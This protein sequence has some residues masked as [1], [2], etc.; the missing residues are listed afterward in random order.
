VKN[1]SVNFEPDF[2]NTERAFHLQPDSGVRRARFL[3][4]LLRY[5][6][7]MRILGGLTQLAIRLHLP[8]DFLIRRLIFNHFCAGETLSAAIPVMERL[9]RSGVHSIPDYSAEGKS[10][11]TSFERV[12]RE[13]LGTLE[14]SEEN[15]AVSHAV[16]KPSGIG[17]FGLWEQLS[18]GA[19][20]HGADL[21]AFEKLE[22]RLDRIFSEASRR[23]V[24]V[25]VDAEETWIQPAIDAMVRRYS[26][27]Y[28]R[29]RVIVYNTLQMYR[30]DRLGF[31]ASE[32]ELARREGYFLGYKIVRGAYHEQEIQR[33]EKMGYPVP[34]YTRKEETDSAYDEAVRFCFANREVIGCCVATHNEEST[35]RLARLLKADS[36]NEGHPFFFAQLYGMSDHITFN[37]AAAGFSVSKYMPYGPLREVIP[38]LLRRAEEN[39]SV[40]GQTGR[41]LYYLDKEWQRRRGKRVDG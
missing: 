26:S 10:D 36:N 6:W 25:M 40:S 3:F 1:D 35:M 37:L 39:R 16:F 27:L 29:E 15:R 19:T 31:L 34:V 7:L 21:E 20:L 13:V 24:A 23:G 9:H 28:N 5:G 38:Y 41:E 8:V 18:T 33:A 2:S 11:E 12:C 30:N 14:L 4:G 22:L 17:S 32:T